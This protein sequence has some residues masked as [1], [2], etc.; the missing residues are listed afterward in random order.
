MTRMSAPELVAIGDNC[1]DVYLTKDLMTVGGNAL[2]VAVQW[3]RQGR[4]AR[5]LGAIGDD[6]EGEILLDEIETAGL[7]RQDVERRRG[8][9]AVT[10]LRHEGG[11]RKFLLES[12]GVGENYQPAA[13]HDPLIATAGWVHLGTNSSRDLVRRLVHEGIPFSVDISTAHRS[14]PLDG[15]PLL[16]ASGPDAASTPVE[17][18]LDAFLAIGARQVVLTCGAR[19]AYFYDGT[20]LLHGPAAP[21][22]VVD[23]CGAGD[24]FI[25]AFLVSFC[26]ERRGAAEAL[27]RATVAAAETCKHIGG[28]P[29]Q[30]RRIPDWL[31]EKYAAYTAPA[32]G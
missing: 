18:I 8:D 16:F 29:Q 22:Q 5:Y 17:P 31:L 19:G 27:H 10:L 3:R 23:T 2:N 9:T 1:L 11:D 32:E 20:T 7:S 21:V 6:A 13:A 25:A 24:S 28:F 14:L 12:L 30:L 15:V 4:A 26:C